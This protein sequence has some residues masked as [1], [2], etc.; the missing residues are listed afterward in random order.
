MASSLLYLNSEIPT[1]LNCIGA[2]LIGYV[3]LKYVRLI[4][5]SY[6]SLHTGANLLADLY[7]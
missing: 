5:I 7:S 3:K 1:M 4:G 6:P 2:K